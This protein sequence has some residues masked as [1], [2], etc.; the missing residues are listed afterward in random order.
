MA[1]QID[2]STLPPDARR[3]YPWQLW[4][5]GSWWEA[6]QGD[7]YTTTHEAFRSNLY[8]HARRH[9]LSVHTKTADNGI[10]FQFTRPVSNGEAALTAV[11]LGAAVIGHSNGETQA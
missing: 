3:K 9:G 5:N 10:A 7:D 4:T 11:A 6:E 2:P 1:K 8:S